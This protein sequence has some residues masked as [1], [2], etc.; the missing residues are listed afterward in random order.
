MGFPLTET[1]LRSIP[2]I[3]RL[4]FIQ[5][6][7]WLCDLSTLEEIGDNE[8]ALRFYVINLNALKELNKKYNDIL[9]GVLELR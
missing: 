1:E 4:K 5:M 3:F 2:E 7:S 8:Q 6:L 9:K